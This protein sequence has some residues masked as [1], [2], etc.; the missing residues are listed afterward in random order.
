MKLFKLA[1]TIALAT[2][3]VD[4]ATVYATDEFESNGSGDWDN[5][6]SWT[7]VTG[8]GCDSSYPE[9]GDSAKV[10]DGDVITLD[11]N[12][13]CGTLWIYDG[14]VDTSSYD[15]TIDGSSGLTI[16]AD[17]LLDVS[18]DGSVTLCGISASHTISGTMELDVAS[19]TLSITTDDTSISGSGEI[20]GYNDSALISIS[21]GKTLTSST[22]ITGHL[23]ISGS[24]NFTNSGTVDAD[25]TGS[26]GSPKTLKV[27]V[28]GILEDSSGDRWK[29]TAAYS[30][31]KFDSS[32]MTI[33]S[34][35]KLAGNFL[36]SS[37]ATAEIE[38][39]KQCLIT[40]GYL[41]MSN[42]VLDV[43]EC[44]IMGCGASSYMAVTGGQIDVATGKSFYH[45]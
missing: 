27:A 18:S 36:I 29:A 10:I 43:Q 3:I 26:E 9:T 4:G 5:A 13:A 7:C 25:G 16:E 32:L 6:A 20:R 39:H 17:E 12:A 37:D 11:A 2:F 14:E 8:G 30:V 33:S 1:L 21:S 35:G 41:Q 44:L 42:G 38:N 22:N 23:E 15:L 34:D 28:T 19:S 45:Y 40:D 31:L 24:G